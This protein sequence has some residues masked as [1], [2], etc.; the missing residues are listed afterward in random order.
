MAK[1]FGRRMVDEEAILKIGQGGGGG[2]PI[3]AGTG[4]SITGTDTKTIAVDEQVVATKE[5]LGDYQ[6]I[7][8]FEFT[9]NPFTTEGWLTKV[10]VLK[11]DNFTPATDTKFGNN[12]VITLDPNN[13]DNNLC[14]LKGYFVIRDTINDTYTVFATTVSQITVETEADSFKIYLGQR[15]GAND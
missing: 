5:D 8:T 4:I 15:S 12:P 3:E 2:T 1:N 6:H 7:E 10:P 14:Y 9:D 13:K 11:T